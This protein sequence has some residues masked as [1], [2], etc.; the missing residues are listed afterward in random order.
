MEKFNNDSNVVN[1]VLV[2]IIFENKFLLLKG[3]EN[4]P[5]YKESFWYVVTGAVED[6]DKTIEDA[7]KREVKEETNLE[8]YDIKYLNW[9]FEYKSLGKRCSEKA[10]FAYSVNNSVILN[11][12]SID[13]KWCDI[14]EFVNEIKWYSDKE[15]LKKILQDIINNQIP[16]KQEK[17]ES[18]NK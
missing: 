4:D 12:E 5:Q 13:Y 10:F 7:V 2:F 3:S 16:F 6:E 9:I 15:E 8:L 14:N 1:K 18:M 17:I 11:E